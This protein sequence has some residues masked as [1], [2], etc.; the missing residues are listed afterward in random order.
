MLLV[1]EWASDG[2][3]GDEPFGSIATGIVLINWVNVQSVMEIMQSVMEIMQSVME[4]MQS[5][6]G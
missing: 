6:F 2:N 4:I 1:W 5:G 3:Q